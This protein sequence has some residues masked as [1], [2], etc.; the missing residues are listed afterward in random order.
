[1]E[2][3]DRG[4]VFQIGKIFLDDKAENLLKNE[5]I[6]KAFLGER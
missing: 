6:K 5:E 3:A 2:F 4:Y 1:L